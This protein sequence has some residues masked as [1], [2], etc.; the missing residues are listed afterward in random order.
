MACRT[1]NIHY[2]L[3]VPSPA[4]PVDLEVL[5]SLGVA[6][7]GGMSVGL[8][9]QWSGHAHGAH[10]HF[11][12]IRTFTMI[13]FVAGVSGWLWRLDLAAVS[14][15]LLAGLAALTVAAYAAASR[16]DIDATTEVAAIVVMAAGTLAGL[17]YVRLGA[18][19]FAVT[20]LLLVEKRRLHGWVAALDRR[21]VRAGARFAVMAAVILPIVPEGPYGPGGTIQP[22][23]LWALVLFFSGLSFVGYIARRIVGAER[24]YA[25]AGTLGGLVSSTSVTLTFAR[26]SN[27]EPSAARALAAGTLGASAFLFPRV[28]LATSV[29]APALA[30]ALWPALV[31]P[32]LVG[33]VLALRGLRADSTLSGD[34]GATASG[35]PGNPLQLAAA[36]QMAALFQIVLFAVAAAR[37]WFGDAGIIGSAAVLGLADL[38]ALTVSM[39]D[40]V[41]RGSAA[42]LAAT[43]LVVGMLSNTLVKMAIALIVGRGR[44]RTLSGIG[45]G[46]MAIT[47]A[48]SLLRVYWGRFAG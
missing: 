18:A 36:L 19:A 8:E 26:L 16:T 12:G 24:G 41:S 2:A 27:A 42:S 4:L 35:P 39:A 30:I 28:L 37:T 44:Y 33:V 40:Q 20:A 46:I 7:L 21:E 22:R 29:L 31:L 32:F 3:R 47:L 9:R 1:G 11:A 34:D 23:L 15:I 45:L 48:A 10:A 38:D 25:L 5:V 43:A 17:G 6:T 14:V 13:G